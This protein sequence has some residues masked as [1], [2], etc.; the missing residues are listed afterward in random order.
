MD[1]MDRPFPPGPMGPEESNVPGPAL[2]LSRQQAQAVAQLADG[3]SAVRV[4]DRGA[5]YFNVTRYNPE[6]EVVDER[7]IFPD[8]GYGTKGL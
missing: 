7:L 8:G 2:R 1:E 4:E 5:C 6:G 3:T